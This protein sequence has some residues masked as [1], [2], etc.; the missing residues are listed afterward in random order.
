MRRLSVLPTLTF[1]T[2]PLIGCEQTP[3]TPDASTA[4]S[5][6]NSNAP[7]QTWHQGFNHDTEGWYGGET[8]GVLGWCGEIE[9]VDR[10]ESDLEPSA[11]R[12]YATV[13]QGECNEHWDEVF[14]PPGAT[15]VNGPYAP[16]P[17]FALFSETWPTSGLATELDIYLD[18]TW[19]ANPL[20]PGTVNF[21]APS[22][23]VFTYLASLRL[24]DSPA[25]ENATFMY[26]GVAV[27]PDNGA[28]SILDHSVTEAGW[29]TFRHVFRD[30]GGELA[31][32]FQLVQRNGGILFTEPLETEF[33]SGEPTSSFVS[34]DLGSGYLF[35]PAISPGIQLPIDE[36]RVR[37]G[38]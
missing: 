35:F 15:L 3:T 21:F 10:R 1:I 22:G 2:M 9:H 7:F 24:L 23:T 17:D 30:E 12:G 5:M 37:Q 29:Y 8:E 25:D 6:T 31:V 26:F 36:H 16:G 34:T 32:D 14:S 11:G 20:E 28:L 38:R 13:A 4:A 18:P 19:T 33:F 27:F